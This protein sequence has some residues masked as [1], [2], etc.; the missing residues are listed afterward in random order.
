MT[1]GVA[2]PIPLKICLIL[3]DLLQLDSCSLPHVLFLVFDVDCL[4]LLRGCSLLGLLPPF[5]FP[6][7]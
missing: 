1:Q 2:C 7:N 3:P 5:P 6:L 4:G